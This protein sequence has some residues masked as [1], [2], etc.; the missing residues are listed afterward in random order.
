VIQLKP[1][2]KTGVNKISS[3]VNDGMINASHVTLHVL[4]KAVT[5]YRPD[6]ERSKELDQRIVPWLHSDIQYYLIISTVLGLIVF[7]TSWGLW[8]KIWLLRGRKQYSNVLLFLV[9][10]VLHRLLFITVFITIFGF[11]CFLYAVVMVVV[12]TINFLFVR[13][14][15]WIIGKVVS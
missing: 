5:V 14:M 11:L 1:A 2:K 6:I 13:P 10:W 8:K 12:R 9:L 7:S 15:R 4:A 3:A